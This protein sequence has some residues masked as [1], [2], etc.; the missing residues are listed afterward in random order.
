[1]ARKSRTIKAQY[2]CKVFQKGERL[3]QGDGV[4]REIAEMNTETYR[5]RLHADGQPAI[6]SCCGW[7][8]YFNH[9]EPQR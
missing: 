7:S 9:G 3:W 2:P 4:L 8:E 6:E 1:M 5:H